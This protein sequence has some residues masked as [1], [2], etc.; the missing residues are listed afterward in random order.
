MEFIFC[1]IN[2]NLPTIS[3]VWGESLPNNKLFAV[4]VDGDVLKQ[5]LVDVSKGSVA[6][7]TIVGYEY[8]NKSYECSAYATDKK[9]YG[10]LCRYTNTPAGTINYYV[11]TNS[12]DLAPLAQY[13]LNTSAFY[14]AFPYGP[15]LA[16]VFQESLGS[17]LSYSYEIWN[18]E[19][20]TL[21]KTRTQFLT[22]DSNSS[23]S[24]F[25]VDAGGLYTLLWDRKNADKKF[26]N[27]QVG[28]LLGSS[29]LSSV[30]GFLLTIIATLLLF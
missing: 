15:H 1:T 26:T 22:I 27:V 13:F 17:S 4:W 25:R 9:L 21:F 23:F 5:A 28:L 11:R 24:L 12:T 18:L 14:N 20:F 29:Y 3:V 30:L 10:E 19:T 16:I 8:Y 2:E 6:N 7:P